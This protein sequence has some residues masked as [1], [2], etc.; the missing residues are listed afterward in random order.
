LKKIWTLGGPSFLNSHRNV[1][2][3]REKNPRELTTR[4]VKGPFNSWKR[5]NP[6]GANM[7]RTTL[8]E[9]K[10]IKKILF[11]IGKLASIFGR[12]IVMFIF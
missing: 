10:K 11:K 4:G 1:C 3:E 9:K 12:N 5:S 7:R 8:L 6:T 2:N